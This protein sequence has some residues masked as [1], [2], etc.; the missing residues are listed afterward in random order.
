MGDDVF[1][2]GHEIA[3]PSRPNRLVTSFHDSKVTAGSHTYYVA[4]FNSKGVGFGSHRVT[5][6]VARIGSQTKTHKR[7]GHR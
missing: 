5:V 6:S 1:R 3:S 2:D 4:G 7:H